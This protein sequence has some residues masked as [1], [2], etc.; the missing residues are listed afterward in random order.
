MRRRETVGTRQSEDLLRAYIIQMYGFVRPNRPFLDGSVFVLSVFMYTKTDVIVHI[1]FALWCIQ[2]R[3]RF[4]IRFFVWRKEAEAVN[5][6][7]H[8]LGGCP[9][10]HNDGAAKKNDRRRLMEPTKKMKIEVSEQEYQIIELMRTIDYGEMVIS[11]K[12]NKP[13]RI[14]EVRKSIQIK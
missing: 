9:A 1:R 10:W 5:G 14:E 8:D 11:I 3:M 2:K 13:I 4:L 6:A 12:G 7:I